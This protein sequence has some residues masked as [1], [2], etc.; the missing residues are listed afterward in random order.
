MEMVLIQQKR[1]RGGKKKRMEMICYEFTCLKNLIPNKCGER[2]PT[3]RLMD[4]MRGIKELSLCLFCEETKD[5][6]SH[7]CL[8]WKIPLRLNSCQTVSSWRQQSPSCQTSLDC[9]VVSCWTSS[10]T[11]PLVCRGW[12]VMTMTIS[13]IVR[14]AKFRFASQCQW[15]VKATLYR[16]FS[17]IRVEKL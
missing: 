9:T 17:A 14:M 4:E 1:E 15:R 6:C 2:T 5:F 7:L 11:P 10:Q 16:S 13:S 8:F 3:R 12:G